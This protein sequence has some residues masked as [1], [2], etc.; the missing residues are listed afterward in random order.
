VGPI[1]AKRLAGPF[2]KFAE[3]EAAG[4]ILLIGCTIAALI[5][6]NSPWAGSYFHLWHTD[7]TFGLAGPRFSQPL[8]FWINDGL[9][10][11]FFLLVGLEIKRETL[12]GELASFRKAALPIAAALGGM[13]IPATFY[14]FFNHGGPGAAGWGIPMAT[15]IAFALGVLALLGNRVPTSLKVFLAALAIVDD[16][17][18]VLVI[19]FFYTEKISWVALG[20]GGLFLAALLAANRAGVR[21]LLIYAALGTG[22]WLTFLQSGIHATVAG[23]LL[24]ATIPARPRTASRAALESNESPMLRLEHTLIPWNRYFIMPVF[25][26]ANAGVA[27]GSDAARSIVTPVSLGVICGLVVGKPVG[28]ILSSWLATRSRLA[29]MLDGIG[30]RQIGGVGILAGIGFTMSLFVA[31]LAFGETPALE[32]AKVGV[33]AASVISGVAGA[34]ALLKTPPGHGPP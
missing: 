31:H 3:L 25:A 34:I 15:D 13:I 1:L 18:A 12:V 11:L 7:V 33:L 26:L 21:H 17:G 4:G 29:A 27:L 8:H 23:V 19:A 16:I 32:T 10:A 22:L 24:A 30:W 14:V 5:W 2:Q 6:S 20:I 9:M 28:V